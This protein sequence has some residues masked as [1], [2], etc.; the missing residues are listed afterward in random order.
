MRSEPLHG[1]VMSNQH[2]NQAGMATRDLPGFGDLLRRRRTAA[3]LSQED[4]PSAQG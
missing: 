2:R 4:W 1:S 3:A